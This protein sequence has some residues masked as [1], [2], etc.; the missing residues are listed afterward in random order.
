MCVCACIPGYQGNPPNCRPECVV[1]SDCNQLTACINQKCV[2]PCPGTCGN[3]AR[4][5]VVN[6]NPICQCPPGYT[7]DAFSNCVKVQPPVA[8]VEVQEDIDPCNPSPCGPFSQCQND[9]TRKVAACSCLPNYIGVPPN[10]RPECSINPDCPSNRACVREK[11]IDP[12]PGS[13]GPNAECQVVNHNPICR[14][15]TGYDGDPFR[16]CR[17]IPSTTTTLR[18]TEIIDPC[19]P[20]PCGSNAQCRSRSR[21]GACTCIPGYFG[22]PYLACRPECVLNTD[23]PTNRACVNNKCVDPCPGV[24]GINAVCNTNRHQPVCTCL[25]GY[26]GDPITQCS[27]LPLGPV[28]PEPTDPCEPNPCG[29][30]SQFREGNGVCICSCEPGMIGSPPNCRPECLVSSECSQSTA[31]IQQQCRDPCPGLCGFNAECR[32]TNHNPICTCN[33]GY[34]GDPFNGCTRIPGNIVLISTCNCS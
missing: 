32:V 34:E 30:Y 7:G 6:H 8:E 17:R 10:C 4:C 28:V 27:L 23:C 2:D 22:D 33:V 26:T 5:Q 15:P 16:E 3:N 13:C 20:T 11:C 24:C 9:V 25:V 29:P 31:C 18:S 21:A 19:N 12:C 1:S 14:C